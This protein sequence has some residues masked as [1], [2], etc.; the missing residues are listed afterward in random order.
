MSNAV[1]IYLKSENGFLY[2]G[3]EKEIIEKIKELKVDSIVVGPG[4][5]RGEFNKKILTEIL[6]ES[7]VPVVIDADALFYYGELNEKNIRR[8]SDYFKPGGTWLFWYTTFCRC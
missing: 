4:L 1:K 5:G 7:G 6:K 3:A 8:D 2:N